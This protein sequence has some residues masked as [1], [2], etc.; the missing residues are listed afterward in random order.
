MGC[1]K[2]YSRY[3][4]QMEYKIDV[5]NSLAYCVFHYYK[6]LE[7]FDELE[8]LIKDEHSK[9]SKMLRKLRQKVNRYERTLRFQLFKRKQK[10]ANSSMGGTC[11]VFFSHLF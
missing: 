3:S 1:R 4:F 8:K 7:M 11:F 5:F 2:L 9:H 6:Q 10:R